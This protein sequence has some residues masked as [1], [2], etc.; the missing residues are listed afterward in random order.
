MIRSAALSGIHPGL[1]LGAA[2]LAPLVVALYVHLGA[3][4]V[5]AG[6]LPSPFDKV[7]HFAAFGVIAALLWTA[8]VSRYPLQLLAAVGLI[9]IADECHQSAL[10]GRFADPL[11]V[12]ADVAGAAVAIVLLHRTFH[13]RSR[14][15]SVHSMGRNLS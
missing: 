3:Q 8:A 6:L 4:P 11:D 5:A 12:L 1:R 2:V 9:G 7:A 14:V 13:A 15:R 10:P